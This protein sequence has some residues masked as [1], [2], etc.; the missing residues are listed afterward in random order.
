MQSIEVEYFGHSAHAGAAPWEGTNALD[1]AFLAYSGISVLRQQIKPDHRIHGVVE[2]RN[3]QANVIPDY[4]KMRWLARAATSNDLVPFVERVQ[5]CLR[6]AAIA[7]GCTIEMKVGEPYFDLHQNSTL[8]QCFADIVS[9]RYGVVTSATGSTASTD[10]GNISYALPALHP[11]FAIP[12]EPNG[13]NHTVAF[14]K[15]AITEAA[16]AATMVV[17][18]GLALTGYRVLSDTHFFER[19]R[20]SFEDQQPSAV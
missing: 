8:A 11:M 9:S 16:H 20:A 2:G 6:A 18:K 17:T 7:T 1:A 19:V 5:N 10:F 3:W 13:G 14:A 4:S 12:T 15:A